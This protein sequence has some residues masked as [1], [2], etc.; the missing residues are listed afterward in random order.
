MRCDLFLVKIH[1]YRQQFHRL[2]RIHDDDNSSMAYLFFDS[3]ENH[4]FYC[5]IFFTCLMKGLGRKLP[6]LHTCKD[7][8][9]TM[10]STF[11][12]FYSKE[13]FS[14]PCWDDRAWPRTYAF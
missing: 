3:T 14:S 12:F 7:I 2:L 5:R 13:F 4:F 9:S 11:F 8:D 1:A 10:T 6:H